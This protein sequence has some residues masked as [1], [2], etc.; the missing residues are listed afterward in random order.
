MNFQI[1][2]FPHLREFKAFIS[3]LDGWLLPYEIISPPEQYR[4]ISV[5]AVIVSE[6]VKSEYFQKAD[7]ERVFSGWVNYTERD[8]TKINLQA[9]EYDCDIF[10]F[11]RIMVLAPCLADKKKLRMVA[12]ISGNLAEIFPYVNS[13][14]KNVVY[15]SQADYLLYSEVYRRIN[16]YSQKITIAKFDDIYDGWRLLESVRQLVNDTWIK[17]DTI[18]P[19]Y[20]S[21]REPSVL[22]IFKLLPQTNCRECGYPTCLAFAAKL[23]AGEEEF[24]AC[25]PVFEGEF[26][27]LQQDLLERCAVFKHI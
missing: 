6:E 27:H 16:L 26:V 5:P 2:T 7:S 20:E 17:R 21:R 3:E 19:K 22:E 9:K 10:G 23:Q 14:L 25:K 15:N 12:H 18:E 11:A 8:L 4:C 13:V 24:T 1:T